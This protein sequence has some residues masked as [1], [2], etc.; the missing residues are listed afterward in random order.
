MCDM[1]FRGVFIV[2]FVS[3]FVFFAYYQDEIT[4]GRPVI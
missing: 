2:L 3:L 1:R 4:C